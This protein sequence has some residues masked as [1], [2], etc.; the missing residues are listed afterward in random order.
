MRGGDYIEYDRQNSVLAI[1]ELVESKAQ[2]NREVRAGIRLIVRQ[3][4]FAGEVLASGVALVATVSGTL[5][6]EHANNR[7]V[8]HR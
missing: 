2:S 8:P 6:S 1:F 4:D 5:R 7:G 3:A